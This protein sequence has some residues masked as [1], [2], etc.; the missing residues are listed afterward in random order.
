MFKSKLAMVLSSIQ[1]R[2]HPI[3]A[4]YLVH[5][6]LELGAGDPTYSDGA[7]NYDFTS[8]VIANY[9]FLSTDDDSLLT[10]ITETSEFKEIADALGIKDLKDPARVHLEIKFYRLLRWSEVIPQMSSTVWST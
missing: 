3:L 5:W 7:V 9:P 10:G 2:Q 1:K 6:Q 8:V 4:K